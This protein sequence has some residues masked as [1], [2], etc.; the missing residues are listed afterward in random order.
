MM[1]K[2]SKTNRKKWL[3]GGLILLLAGVAVAWWIFTEKFED[4]S[5]VQSD[6]TVTAPALIKE[7]QQD[8]K[9][10]NEKYSEK[11]IVVSGTVAKIETVDTTANIKMID[12]QTGDYIIFAFQQQH[13]ASAR[14]LKEGDM[15]S[16]KGSCSNGVYSDIL[17]VTN[18]S[19]KRCAVN[20]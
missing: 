3:I 17:G 20:K 18:I 16:I 4:T 2:N 11:I 10:A 7:F 15:V 9:K 14:A 13:L 6:F 19:F 5:K 8:I 12:S 1:K